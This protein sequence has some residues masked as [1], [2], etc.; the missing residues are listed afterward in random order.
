[1]SRYFLW[2]LIIYTLA[3]TAI[4]VGQIQSQGGPIDWT[5]LWTLYLGPTI[6][7]AVFVLGVAFSKDRARSLGKF[8][9]GLV[10]L[11][12][13]LPIW[14]FVF[15]SFWGGKP[16]HD[17]VQAGVALNLLV[18]IGYLA[19]TWYFLGRLSSD[20][21]RSF[22]R[23]RSIAAPVSLAA[24]ALLVLSSLA[25]RTSF[26]SPGWRVVTMRKGWLTYYASVGQSA[27]LGPTIRWLAPLFGP[28]GYVFYVVGLVASLA[29]IVLLVRFRFSGEKLRAAKSFSRLAAIICLVSLWIFTDIF[30]G[31]HFDLSSTP[32]A[33]VI[34]TGCWLAGLV[35]GGVLLLPVAQGHIE[36]SRLRTLLLFQVPIAAFNV[37]MFPMYFGDS[38]YPGPGLVALIVGLQIATWACMEFMVSD[39]PAVAQKT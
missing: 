2:F 27:F 37:A 14:I 33:A 7:Y 9:L 39:S 26:D 18:G 19:F 25:L 36:P 22:G 16:F 13:F 30:W 3:L 15:K 11:F 24:G 28:V 20:G 12:A 35:L 4:S 38:D 21:P 10:Y 6:A 29:M 8:W 23:T 5:D 32:W 17:W 34:A 1:M 31:W